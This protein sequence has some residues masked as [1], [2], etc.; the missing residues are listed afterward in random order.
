VRRT[1][2]ETLRRRDV[3][4]YAGPLVALLRDPI[5]YEVRPV[6]GPGQPGALFIEGERVNVQRRYNA[7]SAPVVAVN[8]LRDLLTTDADGL[9]VIF[10]N[11][12]TP[13]IVPNNGNSALFGWGSGSGAAGWNGWNAGLG[14]T[15][16]IFVPQLSGPRQV[17]PATQTSG[18]PNGSLARNSS[19]SPGVRAV[20]PSRR[21][22]NQN[23]TGLGTPIMLGQAILATQQAAA[24]AQQQLAN[25]VA[26]LNRYNADSAALNDR[27]VQVLNNA[28][29]QSLPP[30]CDT[31]Q[32]W[33]VDQLGY[34]QRDPD[35][36]PNPT[37]VQ[38]VTPDLPQVQGFVP[39]QDGYRLPVS[40]HSC[41]AA[42]TLVH[43]IEGTRA[44]ETLRIGDVVLT[45]DTKTGALSYHPIVVVH[46]NPPIQTY[47]VRF[48]REAIV[49]SAFHRFWQAGKGWVMA[50]DLK[51]GDALRTLEG[52]ATIEA[53]ETAT[54]QRVF[55]LDVAEN[56]D[57]FVGER[58]TLVHDHTLPALRSEPFDAE[59]A[60]A[61]V[62]G[63]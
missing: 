22:L 61:A 38:Q 46:H 31:W 26:A 63:R 12:P 55:N 42:G 40:H 14:W 56:A 27:V 51:A 53:V 52:V 45:Q 24:T 4:E 47:T 41:F 18:L 6:N 3:R 7:P 16:P 21:P 23:Q 10:R 13:G 34:P 11:S 62:S 37:I 8:P 43:T 20:P 1:A 19:T 2:A 25:D 5:K 48:G 58:G 28:S 29:E 50:R 49:T 39:T 44:I 60:L 35:Q 59:P 17:G 32:R 33:M 54:T 30:E 9:P 36:Q 15:G 57:F